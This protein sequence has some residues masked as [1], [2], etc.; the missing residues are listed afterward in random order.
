[1]SFIS[2]RVVASTSNASIGPNSR[3]TVQLLDV[4]LMDAPSVT[5]SEHVI[6]TGPSESRSFPIPYNLSYD[7]TQIHPHQSISVAARVVDASADENLT[8]ISTTRNYVLTHDNPSDDI[9]VKV[10]AIQNYDAELL[11]PLRTLSGIIIPSQ[12][13]AESNR[14]VGPNS[15]VLIQLLDVSLMDA[16][17]VTLSEQILVTGPEETML[18]PIEFSLQYDP[19]RIE[20]RNTYSV[21]VRVEDAD[22]DN[23][24]WISTSY[25]NV[26]TR[27][28]PSDGVEVNVDLLQ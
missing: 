21:S 3:L 6:L 22:S 12:N 18:F 10:Q 15:K 13:V 24:T 23:L 9:D 17:S 7:H 11:A 5:L 1:M 19:E 27:G 2:G 14:R 26:L 16:P 4:S 20:E 8:W 25:H 28:E